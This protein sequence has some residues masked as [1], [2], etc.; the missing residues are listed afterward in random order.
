MDVHP[1]CP[2]FKSLMAPWRQVLERLLLLLLLMYDSWWKGCL[3]LL[4]LLLPPPLI[5]VA[6]YPFYEKRNVEVRA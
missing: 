4:M 2:T 3:M 1:C 5:V 6:S